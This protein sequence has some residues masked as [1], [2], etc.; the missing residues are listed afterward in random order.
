MCEHFKIIKLIQIFLFLWQVKMS[1]ITIFSEFSNKN[2]HFIINISH[3][4]N[5]K[6]VNLPKIINFSYLCREKGKIFINLILIESHFLTILKIFSSPTNCT[7]MA[8]K[9]TKI[10]LQTSVIPIWNPENQGYKIG[11][12]KSDWVQDKSLKNGSEKKCADLFCQ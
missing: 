2:T 11:Y 12:E 4:N 9:R 8:I 5:C 10:K 7:K 6:S 3:L 1:E